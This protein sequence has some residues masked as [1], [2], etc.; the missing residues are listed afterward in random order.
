MGWADR[1][2][3]LAPLLSHSSITVRV[4]KANIVH[5]AN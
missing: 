2:L 3:P 4:Q 5:F 1:E